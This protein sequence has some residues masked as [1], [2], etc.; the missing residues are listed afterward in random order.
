MDKRKVSNITSYFQVVKSTANVSADSEL[1]LGKNIVVNKSPIEI[2]VPD[3]PFH[4]NVSYVFPK[5]MFG[6]QNRFCNSKFYLE[7]WKLLI[8]FGTLEWMSCK[9]NLTIEIKSRVTGCQSQMGK[10]D[11][12]FGLHLG[13]RLYSHTD[14]I[15]IFHSHLSKSL[16]SEKNV[17]CL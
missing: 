13:H 6:K 5:R 9:E 2:R 10:F 8:F 11:L 15:F 17:C 3:K 7:S 14:K 4:P 16:Q 1:T 12:F